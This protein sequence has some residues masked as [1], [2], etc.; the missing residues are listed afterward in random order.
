MERREFVE[1]CALGASG[2]SA[3]MGQAA[4]AAQVRPKS[5]ERVL[6][7]DEAGK[8]LRASS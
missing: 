5:Y 2:A 4:W 1:A 3:L 8:P 7:V 6:L